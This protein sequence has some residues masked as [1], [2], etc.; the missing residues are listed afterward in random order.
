[1]L[2]GDSIILD[3]NLSKPPL[4]TG[5]ECVDNQGAVSFSIFIENHDDVRVKSK[6]VFSDKFSVIVV[7][8]TNY[9]DSEQY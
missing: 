6:N 8:I 9:S 1:M 5:G 7:K 4:D 2:A 3:E